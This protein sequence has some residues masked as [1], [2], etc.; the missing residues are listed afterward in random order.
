MLKKP[1]RKIV[2]IIIGIWLCGLLSAANAEIYTLSDGT[3]ITGDV[4]SFNDD[5][6][7][8]RTGDDKYTDRVLWTKFSQ[9]A[10][11][12]LVKNPKLKEYVEPFIETPPPPSRAQA[13]VFVHQVSRLELPPEQTII[14]ALFSSF[15]GV[16]ILFLVYAANIYAGVEVAIFRSR[17]IAAVAGTAAV[18]PILGPII[19]LSMPTVMAPGATEEDMQMET[20]APAA[21][22]A[23][24]PTSHGA[25]MPETT[26]SVHVAPQAAAPALPETEVF[27]RGK[28]TFNRRFF[29]TKFSGFFGMTRHGAN[30]DIVLLVKTPKAQHVVERITRI[31]A[32]D[33]HL[34]VVV[35]AAHQEVMVPFADI[36][37][38]QLKHKDA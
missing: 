32:N 34:D 20:G 37:E 22:V 21:G 16:L 26:E 31:A 12:L 18:L 9:D 14:G 15:L 2:W 38:I 24:T 17:P 25:P 7:V 27:Q 3:Q 11:K 1:V 33:V 36:Q 30:K 28:F 35:G 6:V 10:L 8:F 5:G 4:I 13:P 23:P 19:F 29:E